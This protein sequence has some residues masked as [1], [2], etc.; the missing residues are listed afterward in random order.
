MVMELSEALR[1]TG[2]VRDFRPEPVPD[3]VLYRVL[4]T[5]RFG[6]S[7]GNKQGW[8]VVV[9][10]D[11]AKRRALRDA[12]LPGWYEYVALTAGGLRP[13][14]P[15]ND[16]AAEQ[17]VLAS[18]GAPVAEGFAE[19]LHEAPVL[20]A[21]FVDLGALAAVDR[22]FDRYSFA[23]GASVYP[24]VWNVLLAGRDEGLGGVITTMCIHEEPAVKALFDVPDHYALATVLALGYPTRAARRLT[25]APVESF[26]SVD[27][28]Q[29]RPFG[30]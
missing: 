22:D 24:F 3:D 1:T 29:G 15:T 14:A 20:L 17:A 11:E 28:M 5:A 7:G 13:W 16:R 19:H 9:V 18:P 25:R 21:V 30:S 6:P 10:K 2:A 12:Y 26:V 27:S 23:G 4:D 8:H